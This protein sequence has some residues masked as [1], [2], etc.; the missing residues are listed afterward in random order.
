MEKH[1]YRLERFAMG[2]HLIVLAETQE[3][4]RVMAAAF[5]INENTINRNTTPD[6]LTGILN[7]ASWW[8]D[9][10]DTSISMIESNL[11]LKEDVGV[12]GGDIE[13]VRL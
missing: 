1:L 10:K 7:L 3:Q 8:L 11:L 4:A 13:R 12:I 5:V 2:V 9:T 6:E